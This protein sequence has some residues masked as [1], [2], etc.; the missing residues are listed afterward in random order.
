MAKHT[1][2]KLKRIFGRLVVLLFGLALVGIP[3]VVLNQ[4][5]LYRVLASTLSPKHH[6]FQV[7]SSNRIAVQIQPNKEGIEWLGL[8]WSE[9][10]KQIEIYNSRSQI[11][12]TKLVTVNS[13]NG[14]ITGVTQTFERGKFPGLTTT[15]PFSPNEET[16][17]GACLSQNIFFSGK[18]ITYGQWEPRLWKNGQ[19]VK[20]FQTIEDYPDSESAPIG[21]TIEFSKFSPGCRYFTKNFSGQQWLLDT[22]KNSFTPSIKARYL[23]WRDFDYPYQNLQANWSPSGKEFVFGDGIFGV[24]TYNIE[25]NR[26]KWVL[27][28]SFEG[29][30]PEWSNSGK[31]ISVVVEKYGQNNQFKLVITSPNGNKVSTLET[32]DHMEL[33]EWSPVDDRIGFIC[34]DNEQKYLIIWDLSSVDGN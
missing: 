22:L 20:S 3:I 33:P 6:I 11:Y 7:E 26:R 27:E 28:P 32:C 18:E 14:T 21:L 1:T 13:E 25:T 29:F 10:G 4:S 19:L 12:A 31:W 5:A 30:N 17:W 9:N 8:R 2:A 24:E 16:L 15:L 23:V 34:N